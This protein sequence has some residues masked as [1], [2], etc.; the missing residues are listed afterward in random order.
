MLYAVMTT[1]FQHSKSANKITVCISIG[2]FN[3]ITDAGL[4]TQVDN[5]LETAFGEEFSHG[6]PVCKI[7]L[8]ELE[9]VKV[10]QLLQSGL[11]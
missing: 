8:L 7:K 11:F 10:S 6:F 3:R 5:T 4:G 9:M 2:I 1:P